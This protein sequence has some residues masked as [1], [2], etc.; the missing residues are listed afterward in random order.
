M[1]CQNVVGMLDRLILFQIFFCSLYFY[2]SSVMLLVGSYDFFI[3][4]YFQFDICVSL[5]CNEIR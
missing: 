2:I 4:N 3:N 1:I 5:S